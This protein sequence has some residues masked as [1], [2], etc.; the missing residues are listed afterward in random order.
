M[1]SFLLESTGIAC[2]VFAAL[3]ALC[4]G[5]MCY[6]MISKGWKSFKSTYGVL[7]FFSVIRLASQV[8][9][10]AYAKLGSDNQ[11]PLLVP[12]LVLGIVGFI[13]LLV[14]AMEYI[15]KGQKQV[16]DRSWISHDYLLGGR[17]LRLPVIGFFVKAFQSIQGA[18]N[19]VVMVSI[20][21]AIAG[22]SMIDFEDPSQSSPTAHAL[23]SAG[24]IIQL[25]ITIVLVSLNLYVIL[26]D[27]VRT[28]HT[29]TV[30]GSSPFF[31]IRGIYGV[32]AN[33]I[34]KMNFLAVAN[35]TNAVARRNLTIYQYVL[36]NAMELIIFVFLASNYFFE[37]SDSQLRKDEEKDLC[38]K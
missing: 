6:I 7:G 10:I 4:V 12:Y 1:S 21:L 28:H 15:V 32:L 35:Y 5:L 3:F 13:S 17:K 25:V 38:S 24:L 8:V 31:L 18:Y 9:G 23:R 29:M 37:D 22:T 11:H 26:Q 30:L 33:Y 34:T 36:E 27:G 2:S 16:F 19:L 20:A 14:T